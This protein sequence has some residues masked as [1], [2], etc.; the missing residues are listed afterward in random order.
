[1]GYPQA[2]GPLVGVPE[3]PWASSAL[4]LTI[5]AQLG[6]FEPFDAF[7]SCDTTSQSSSLQV[8]SAFTF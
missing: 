6:N 4:H 1:M 8:T 5:D 3:F 7:S 2:S